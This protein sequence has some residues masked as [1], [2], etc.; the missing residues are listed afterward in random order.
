L[1]AF[2]IDVLDENFRTVLI[3]EHCLNF[4]EVFAETENVVAEEWS[5]F[6]LWIRELEFESVTSSWLVLLM[7][8]QTVFSMYSKFHQRFQF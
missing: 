6:L 5:N 1:A 8:R 2:A 3:V 7:W 4:S